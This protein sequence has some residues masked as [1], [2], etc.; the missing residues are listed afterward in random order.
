MHEATIRIAGAGPFADVTARTGGSIDLWCNDHCDLLYVS[1]DD[2]LAVLDCIDDLVGVQ[3]H[4]HGD[5]EAVVI[6]GD[7]LKPHE[8]PLVDPYLA[9]HNCLVLPPLVYERG[10]K[11]CRVLALDSA[12]LTSFYRDLVTDATVSVE[13]KREVGDIASNAPLLTMEDV[14]SALSQRQFEVLKT[15]YELGYYRIP[16]DVTTA[17]IGAAVGVDRRTAEEH[18]RRAENKLMDAVVDYVGH[19]R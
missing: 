1:D 7:C 15:A 18:L 2:P 12:N 17:E 19:R 14:L 16:R 5:G 6:T 8:D 10:A 4:I 9:R 3:E 13:S 11:F